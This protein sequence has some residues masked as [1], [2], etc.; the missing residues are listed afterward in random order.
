M[1]GNARRKDSRS[2]E[3]ATVFVHT[4]ATAE[5]DWQNEVLTFTR[6]PA[7]GEYF[8]TAET[9][10]WYRITLVVHCP[11]DDAQFDAEAFAMRADHLEAIGAAGR[12]IT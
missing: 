3:S 7:V 10:P 8:T 12:D 1:N 2:T 5:D 11:W 4:K 6:V 9:E